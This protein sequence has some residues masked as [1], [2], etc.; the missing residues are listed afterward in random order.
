[1]GIAAITKAGAVNAENIYAEYIPGRLP[2]TESCRIHGH[3]AMRLL[4]IGW[5]KTVDNAFQSAMMAFHNASW[6]LSLVQLC[7]GSRCMGMGTSEPDQRPL[8]QLLEG[9]VPQA[10]RT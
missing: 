2:I 10:G 4:P 6:L 9:Q 8:G 7:T 5:P 3:N 1:L